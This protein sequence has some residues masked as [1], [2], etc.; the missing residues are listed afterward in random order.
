ML[1][2]TLLFITAC[3]ASSAC[4]STYHPEY[5]PVTVTTIH[6]SQGATP[7]VVQQPQLADPEVFFQAP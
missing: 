6:Q 2:R 4:T 7:V 1:A 5:H 3:I